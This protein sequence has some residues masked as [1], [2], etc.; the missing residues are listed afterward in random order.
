MRGRLARQKTFRQRPRKKAVVP[1]PHMPATAKWLPRLPP[2]QGCTETLSTPA[3]P[4][5]SRTLIPK[6][7]MG[8][9]HSDSVVWWTARGEPGA[10]PHPAVQGA[11][12]PPSCVVSEG[13]WGTRASVITQ[14]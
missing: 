11:L 3:D 7:L 12:D 5:G 6:A 14:L 10:P 2:S 1:P 8:P 9:R 13:Q 4:V